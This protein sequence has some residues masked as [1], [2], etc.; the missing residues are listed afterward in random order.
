[1]LKF[2][3]KP[4][5]VLFFR[6][7]RPF[8]VG[9]VVS[10]IFPPFPHTFAGAIS[11]IIY[12]D[13][14]VNDLLLKKVYGPFLYNEKANKIYFPKPTDIYK[15]RKK[16]QINKIF[17]LELYDDSNLSLFKFENSNKPKGIEKLPMYLGSEEAESFYG[18]ISEDGLQKWI[19]GEEVSVSDIAESKD[20][21]EYESRVGIRQNIGTHTVVEED[22]LYRIKFLRLKQDW[23]FVFYVEFDEEKIQNKNKIKEFYESREP[24]VIKLG[25]EM[26]TAFYRV[27]TEDIRE[28]FKRPVLKENYFKILFL[29]PATFYSGLFPKGNGIKVISALINGFVNISMYSERLKISNLS[30]RGIK[31]GSV[32]YL[33]KTDNI[34]MDKYWFAELF[35]NDKFFG[36]NLVIYGKLCK[37]IEGV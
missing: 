36:S 4:F 37:C 16:E 15:E 35:A 23:S 20:I 19:N 28:R 9:G 10:S 11:S 7:S 21:F 34:D 29:T 6:D 8:N 5:D 32:F 14:K 22:G 2:V 30:R 18:F 26:K 13:L 27:E 1:M 12:Q 33:E 17:S 3:I 25:G 31:A 24:R